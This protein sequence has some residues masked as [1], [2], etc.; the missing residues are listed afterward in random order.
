[1][2]R[3]IFQSTLVLLLTF[4]IIFS[5][6]GCGPKATEDAEQP[7]ATLPEASEGASVTPEEDS[8][9]SEN[10]A[11]YAVAGDLPS[12]DP[13]YMLS[14]D[15]TV[16]FNVYETLTLW[17]PDEGV[18]PALATEWES[19]AEGTEW[20]FKLREGVKFHDGSTLDANDVKASLDRNIGVGM[21]AY[22]FV[23]VESI[24]AVDDL[25]V[26]FIASEPRNLP[27]ILTASYGMFIYTSEAAEM[28]D[29]EWFN[30]GND[31][32]SG[33]YKV[34]S[35]EPGKSVILQ[36]FPDYW[37]GWQEGQF[38]QVILEIVED[39]TVRDQMIRS[40]EADIAMQLPFDSLASLEAIDELTVLPFVPLAFMIGGFDLNSAPL[41]NLLVR[42]ALVQTYPYEDVQ[43]TVFL[44]NGEIPKGFGTNFLWDPPEDFPRWQYDLEA[45]RALLE[46]AGMAD[47]FE[48]N[49]A[50]LTGSQEVLSVAELWKAELAKLNITLNVQPLS[51]GAFWDYA[52]NPDNEEFNIFLMVP[53]GDIPALWPELICYT[54]TPYGWMPYIQYNN[55]AFDELVFQAWAQEATDPDA[56]RITWINAQRILHDDAV[57]V[58]MLDYPYVAVFTDSLAGY[59]PNEAYVSIIFF[60]QLR[61]Q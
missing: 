3:K 14:H 21:V 48:L 13:P 37:G 61:R 8:Q 12:L 19:N 2:K 20:T 5:A 10:S 47:G 31:A 60:Y 7:E 58:F 52:Y 43:Q 53:T 16:G 55:P 57:S 38:T 22:D 46:Q 33:P 28:N 29:S 50:L 6:S 26:R 42:Q 44:G 34:A 23:G 54:S 32:G 25:T 4:V 35:F 27:L 59:Q 36:M 45:A 18:I 9:I 1:M 39:P 49:A 56:A 30:A 15:T 24:E 41:D 17:T 51:S 40:G 11:T